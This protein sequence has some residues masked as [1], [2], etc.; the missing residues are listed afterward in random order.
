MAMAGTAS[1]AG[2]R[3]P[4]LRSSLRSV[5]SSASSG[6]LK[7]ALPPCAAS[8][9][10]TTRHR[11]PRAVV[12]TPAFPCL[13]ANEARTQR[14]LS[15]QGPELDD[16]T[17][18]STST[19]S[20]AGP[21]PSY[22][23]V[24]S[25]YKTYHHAEPLPLDYGGVL[26]EYDVAYETWGQLNERKDNAILI[27]TGLSA[28]SHAKSHAD[29]TARG[30]WEEFIGPG[31]ALDTDRFFVICTNVLGG[32]Y[33]S[34]GPSSVHPLDSEGGRYGTRFPILSIFDMVRAQFHLLDSL[35]IRSLFASVGS[36]MGGMQSI[37]AAHLE[38][39]R[40]QRVISI[41]GCARS[42]PSSIALRFAQRSG[43]YRRVSD[44]ERVSSR[45]MFSPTIL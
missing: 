32:C 8:F 39:E 42:G 17:S 9:S 19:S 21:E 40:V 5:S 36:S 22:S 41:S 15:Q 23:F 13:D 37:A 10:S 26:P 2:L 7:A 27:H 33:G 43:K 4:A 12:D 28:S 16:A 20:S 11:K 31:K 18:T 24:T 6:F 44:R 25:G 1:A 14:L 38:P 29:N 45:G 35:G 3:L 30:W 34:T